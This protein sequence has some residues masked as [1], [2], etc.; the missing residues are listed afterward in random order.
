MKRLVLLALFPLSLFAAAPVGDWSP[1]LTTTFAWQNNLSNGEAV[2]DRFTTLQIGA[3]VLS[4]KQFQL[5]PYDAAHLTLHL[6]GDW[7]PRFTALDRGVGGVRADWQHTFGH[8]KI[9]PVFTFEA[10][11][12]GVAAQET[13]RRGW[14]SAATLR[15]AQQLGT[16]WRV[17]V[18]ERFEQYRANSTVFDRHDNETAVEIS[19]DLNDDTRL[20]LSG[21]WRNGDVVT[22]A[23][24]NRPDLLAIARASEPLTTFRT[25]MT[26]YATNADTAAGKL[27][28]IHA[29]SEESA[30][31]L[32]Y[33]YASTRRTGLRFANQTIAVSFV[34]QY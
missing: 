6:G 29:T 13:A 12:D 27:A 23:Q 22:Y 5:A 10:A 9:A 25:P 28:L 15:L 18:S 31:A 16:A 21:R 34:R 8:G 1:N 14:Q 4:S 17:A 20:V 19:H 33:E 2:W 11:G 26:A 24:Y 3:D 7:I 30:V 32:S